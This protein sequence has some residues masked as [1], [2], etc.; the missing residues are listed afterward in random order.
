MPG[1]T[2]AKETKGL[3]RCGTCAFQLE[4]LSPLAPET[5]L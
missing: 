4:W 3:L 1:F 5:T 2:V